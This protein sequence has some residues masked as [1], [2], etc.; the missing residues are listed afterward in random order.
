MIDLETEEKIEQSE[1]A[2]KK[3]KKRRRA[4]R[5]RRRQSAEI[6]PQQVNA[7]SKLEAIRKKEH[8]FW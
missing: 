3:P 6:D 2:E 8:S 4:E 7:F 1:K 5:G